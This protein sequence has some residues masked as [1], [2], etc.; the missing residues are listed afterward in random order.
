MELLT[1]ALYLLSTGLLVPVIVLLLILF[2]RSLLLAG[3]TYGAWLSRLRFRSALRPLLDRLDRNNVETL[4]READLPVEPRWKPAIGR[5]LDHGRSAAQ[6]EKALADFETACEEDLAAARSMARLGPMLGLMG[7]LIPMGPALVG[8]AAGDIAAMA[9]NLQVAFSTTV[10]GLF[11]GAIGF[12]VQQAKQRWHTEALGDL[13]FV[14]GLIGERTAK[15]E[16]GGPDDR[17]ETAAE[18]RRSAS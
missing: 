5:L 11:V 18:N 15:P 17:Q 13:E 6:R 8:L 16:T 3:R 2:A 7:T 4:L 1:R 10:V 9:E 14:S 12:A